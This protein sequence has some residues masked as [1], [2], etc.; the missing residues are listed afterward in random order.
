MYYNTKY[1]F[2]NPSTSLKLAHTALRIVPADSKSEHEV[3]LI[4]HFESKG[5]SMTGIISHGDVVYLIFDEEL[6]DMGKARR[7]D[8]DKY[9]VQSLKWY[10]QCYH[11]GA[12]ER[13]TVVDLAAF[14]WLDEKTHIGEL[15][16][17]EAKAARA[18]PL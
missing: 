16:A 15:E 4:A 14:I 1:R 6:P 11:L 3:Y 10:D 9:G 17:E 2:L 12:V 7:L 18:A 13:K 5:Q 8:G